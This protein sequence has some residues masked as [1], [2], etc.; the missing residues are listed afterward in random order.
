MIFR[1]NY[2]ACKIVVFILLHR[3]LWVCAHLQMCVCVCVLY[4]NSC[5]STVGLEGELDF[6][7]WPICFVAFDMKIEV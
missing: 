2:C 1:C 5:A 4:K 7:Y 6:T 3:I